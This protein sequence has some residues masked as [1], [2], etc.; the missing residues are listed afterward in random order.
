METANKQPLG[1]VPSQPKATA[2]K[3]KQAAKMTAQKTAA[4]GEGPDTQ[5]FWIAAR[6]TAGQQAIDPGLFIEQT[7]R[8]VAEEVGTKPASA[9]YRRRIWTALKGLLDAWGIGDQEIKL[10]A[11]LQLGK[12]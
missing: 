10:R 8:G 12:P 4:R 6:A 7:L 11:I 9:A 2:S 3:V 1:T 5:D